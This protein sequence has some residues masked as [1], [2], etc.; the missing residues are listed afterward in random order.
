VLDK[1]KINQSPF[2][3]LGHSFGGMI[4]GEYAIKHPAQVKHLIL[5]SP[6][7]MPYPAD[8]LNVDKIR[9]GLDKDSY[10]QRIGFET[11]DW[12]W[13]EYHP[14]PFEMSRALGFLTLPIIKKSLKRRLPNMKAEVID[15]FAKYVH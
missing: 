6:L 3:L 5:M 11:A 1:L 4:A 15:I 10:L 2:Y 7:G 14:S 12:L 13:N 8:R 9:E